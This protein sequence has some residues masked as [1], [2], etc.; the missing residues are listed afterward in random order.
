MYE[1]KL[2]LDRMKPD[3]ENL[4]QECKGLGYTEETAAEF[5]NNKT[6]ALGSG[7][8]KCKGIGRLAER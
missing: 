7:C 6:V 2:K 1:F 5:K 8:P 4:C 3:P